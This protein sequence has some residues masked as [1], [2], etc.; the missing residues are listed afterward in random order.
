M[1]LVGIAALVHGVMLGLLRSQLPSPL[2]LLV[3]IAFAVILVPVI[4]LVLRVF[5]R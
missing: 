3:Q 5:R 2:A 4:Y 1:V